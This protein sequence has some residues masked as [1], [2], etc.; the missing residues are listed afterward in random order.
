MRVIDGTDLIAGRLATIV[1]KLALN[2]EVI[3]I[4]NSEKVIISGNPKT[5]IKKFTERIHKGNALTGPYYPKRADRILKRII[6]GMLPY[7]TERGR[8]ALS[9]IKTFIGVPGQLIEHVEKLNEATFKGS[10]IIKYITIGELSK[11]LGGKFEA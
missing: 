3:R 8:K 2:G 5:I 6:R 7:K 1:A 10:N 11:Q 9:R 4:V